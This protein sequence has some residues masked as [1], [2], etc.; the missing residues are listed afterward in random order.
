MADIFVSYTS[1][2]RERAFWIGDELEKLGH[3]P[4]V[5]EWEIKAGDD[6]CAWMEKRFGTAD[7]VLCV[8]S[9]EYL[10]APFSTLERNAALWSAASEG[11]NSALLV[12]V[13]QCEI[14]KL[15]RHLKRCDISGLSEDEARFAFRMFMQGGEIARGRTELRRPASATT[16]V[17]ICV[18]PH[19][20]GREEALA[21]IEATLA[22]FR[23]RIA[24]RGLP[25]VG[26]STLAANYAERHRREYRATWWVRAQSDEMMRA[27]LIGLGVR[28]NWVPADAE[29]KCAFAA[30]SERL[31]QDGDGILLI[32][33]NALEAR[34]LKPYLPRGGAAQVLIT[35]NARAWGDVATPIDIRLWPPEIGAEYLI[36]RTGRERESETALVL[37]KAMGGLPLALEQAAA[38]CERL[39]ISLAEYRKR[40]EAEP[41]KHL[42]DVRD[43]PSDYHDG[44]TVAKTFGLAIEEAGKLH[45]AAEPLM[46]YAALLAPEPIPLFLFSDGREK[47][48]E[49]LASDLAGD[50]LDE[51]VAA[52]LAF[53]LLDRETIADE[54]EP[55]ETTDCIRLHRLVAQVAACRRDAAGRE[56]A[57]AALLEVLAATYPKRL[58]AEP[59]AWQRARRLDGAAMALLDNNRP[60][61]GRS[62]ELAG[63]LLDHLA[64]YRHAALA[65]YDQ[66]QPL[67][68]R[69]LKIREDVLG[70]EH[71][72]TAASINMLGVLLHERGDFDRAEALYKRALEIR[73]KLLGSH[74]RDTATTLNN[75]AMLLYERNRL[76]EARELCERALAIRSEVIGRDDPMTATSLHNLAAILQDHGDLEGARS[77][78]ERALEIR[79]TKLGFDHP[80][81]ARTLSC[82]GV[83]LCRLGKI[84]KAHTL[85]DRA[86][87]IMDKSFDACHPSMAMALEG[88]ACVSE[89]K[90]DLAGALAF[91]ERAVGIQR[92][93]RP[94]HPK[95][96]EAISRLARLKLRLGNPKEAFDLGSTALESHIKMFGL[97]HPWTKD[98]AR[99]V[100]DALHALKRP[101]EAAA[102][103][104]QYGI[105]E[106]GVT[107]PRAGGRAARRRAAQRPASPPVAQ[108][109]QQSS[110]DQVAG[111]RVP[112]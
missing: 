47:F 93:I 13:K 12:V 58:W 20:L 71:P 45:P 75:C 37:S 101:R 41:A 111:T 80:F 26:K 81:T 24:L 7:R 89:T 16:N 29:A 73:E 68:E 76:D 43:A 88:L 4:H 1:S 19:F 28:L 3:R 103:R 110:P 51:A 84:D 10:K 87:T 9:E 102:I 42:D 25:G 17:P 18:P 106:P 38:Y 48:D 90:G 63:E 66:A 35:S 32:F 22:R 21:E 77:Y 2:D 65:M 72:D 11:A 54:R 86:K 46:V 100:A 49:P 57:E 78:F 82:L 15:Y 39:Q 6:I 107:Y 109:L 92:A 67:Y 74:H 50:G 44:R 91:L 97:G 105:E 55:A 33:D 59:K 56:H 61:S 96:V 104:Q 34:T 108:P 27:D 5:H 31:Q 52:L 8:V 112:P 36:K 23:G 62:G 40:F 60:R 70:A 95:T 98:A 85:C 83:V 30:V 79:Q 64:T 69:A 99:I 14:P 53:G 94:N